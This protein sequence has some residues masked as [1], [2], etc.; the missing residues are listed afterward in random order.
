M[1]ARSLTTDER[2]NI[3]EQRLQGYAKEGWRIA[4]QSDTTAQLMKPKQFNFVLAVIFLLLGGIPF[5]IYL[6]WYLAAKD[7]TL[8]LT[9]DLDGTVRVQ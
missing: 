9:V 3:L 2:K 7:K 5:V 6:F 1:P 8:Y 4:S